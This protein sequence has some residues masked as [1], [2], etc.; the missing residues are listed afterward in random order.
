MLQEKNEIGSVRKVR[1]ALEK[2]YD[3]KVSNTYV[4]QILKKNLNMK[5]KKFHYVPDGANT[6]KSIWLR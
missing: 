2:S 4:Q 5:F 6:V 3:I 1:E